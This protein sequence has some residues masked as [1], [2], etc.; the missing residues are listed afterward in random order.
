MAY[1]RFTPKQIEF[2]K[3][4]VFGKS[5]AEIITLVNS[6]FGIQ[7][8]KNQVKSF[9]GNHKLNSGRT[10]RFESGHAPFNK[11]KTG[12]GGWEPTQFKKGCKSWNYKP[13]GSERI[14]SDGY[15]DIKI[16][17]PN[18]WRP[19]HLLI[20]EAENA[21]VPKGHVVI[22]GD[23]NRLNLELDNLILVSRKELAILN[24]NRL[25]HCSAELTRSGI[26]IADIYLKYNE[27][28]KGLKRKTAKKGR[29]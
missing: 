20:W 10:G 29:S 3:V 16:A 27:R 2:I 28:N 17:D 1:H 13:V 21:P 14:N 8:N 12:I 7:L 9:M 24:K 25:I 19:K 26:L 6:Q 4:N 22:F 5:Y 11:G 18:K 15:V 23:G